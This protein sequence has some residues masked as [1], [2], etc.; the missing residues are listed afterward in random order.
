MNAPVIRC[1]EVAWQLLGLS[2]ASWN[3]L[4]SLAVAAIWIAAA[5]AP[6]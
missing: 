4:A 6:R 5:R 2:M 1:D 3:M